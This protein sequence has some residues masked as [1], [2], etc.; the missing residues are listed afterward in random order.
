MYCRFNY[1]SQA[2]G[3]YV[4]VT[5]VIPT[6]KFDFSKGENEDFSYTKGMKYQTIY[7]MHGGGD[8]NTLPYRF[9]SVERYAEDNV[10]M[11]VTPNIVHSFGVDTEYGINYATFIGEELPKLIRVMF[12]SSEKKEDNF[13]MGFAMGGNVALGTALRYPDLF[14]TCVDISGGIGM[15][16]S[17]ETMVKSLEE[18][19]GNSTI[20]KLYQSTF[21]PA[22]KFVG[23][24]NDIYKMAKEYKEKGIETPKFI[25]ALG[26]EEFIRP[27]VEEDVRIF[28]ELGY[29]IDYYLEE[30]WP[31]KW[32]FWDYELSKM[33]YEYLPLKRHAIYPNE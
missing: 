6:K 11:L 13:I 4:D 16:L 33:L 19:Y 1:R 8:E 31:H 20:A 2:L 17:N 9:T 26:S 5:V 32:T 28:R 27:R 3:Y 18:G 10:V 30:G 23:G 21:G 15:S 24:K 29:D 12:P 22:D 7:L 14:S 25:L